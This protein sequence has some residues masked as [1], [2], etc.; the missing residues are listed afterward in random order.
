[1]ANLEK[2]V[3]AITT[4]IAVIEVNGVYIRE[5]MDSIESKMDTFIE[6]ADARYADKVVERVV[7]GMVATVLTIV[8]GA[9][10]AVVIK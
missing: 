3:G 10:V 1:M 7:Y 9:V 6:S 8:V 5:R 4:K 2:E